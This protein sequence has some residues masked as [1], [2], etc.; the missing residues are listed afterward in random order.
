MCYWSPR[1]C[2]RL[3]AGQR[4]TGQLGQHLG[5]IDA[6]EGA[7]RRRNLADQARH[8]AGELVAAADQHDLV[9]FGQRCGDFG[10]DLFGLKGTENLS[11][12]LVTLTN[13]SPFRLMPFSNCE[14]INCYC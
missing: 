1:A 12:I 7:Q 9:G 8:V 3:D 4:R 13:S 10:G 14:D 11:S 5:Q 2:L 6:G